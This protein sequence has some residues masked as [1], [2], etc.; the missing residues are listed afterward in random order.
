MSIKNDLRYVRLKLLGTVNGV[1]TA[2][3]ALGVA[4]TFFYQEFIGSS[5]VATKAFLILMLLFTFIAYRSTFLK[6]NRPYRELQGITVVVTSYV[7]SLL[8]SYLMSSRFY[9]EANEPTVWLGMTYVIQLAIQLEVLLVIFYNIGLVIADYTIFDVFRHSTKLAGTTDR[10]H[11]SGV[12][13]SMVIFTRLS[14]VVYE[15]VWIVAW[16]FITWVG[17]LI[18]GTL[19][20]SSE[21]VFNLL[22]FTALTLLSFGLYYELGMAPIK[23]ERILCRRTIGPD[24]LVLLP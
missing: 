3:L 23:T 14:T 10:L 5:S 1:V 15:S 7:I 6:L 16:L 24:L 19:P 4:T 13:A 2:T 11:T 20:F 17:I 8:Y 9:T 21:V 12:N 18:V 22:G